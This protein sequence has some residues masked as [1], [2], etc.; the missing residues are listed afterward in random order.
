MLNTAY[1]SNERP[2]QRDAS[3]W[4]G[5]GDVQLYIDCDDVDALHAELAGR[6]LVIDPPERTGYGY[7]AIW[8][9][10]PD[11]YRITFHQL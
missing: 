8:T 2:A 9:L 11:G 10:D 5:H 3:R 6:G 4:R 7:R 1:D